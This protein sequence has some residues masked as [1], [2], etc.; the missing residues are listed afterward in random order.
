MDINWIPILTIAGVVYSIVLHELAHAVVACW[1]GDRTAK[2]LGRITLNPIPNLSVIGSLVVPIVAYFG[3]GLIIGW[4]KPVPVVPSNY[5]RRVLGDLLVSMAG[6][7]VN[8]VLAFLL[9]LVTGLLLQGKHIDDSGAAFQVMGR[10][11]QMNVLLA[12]FNLIPIPPLDGHH[13]A[14]Y[15]LPRRLRTHYERIGFAG[16]LLVVVLV[17][18]HSDRLRQVVKTVMEWLVEVVRYLLG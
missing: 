4:A 14:K 11:A 17:V 3:S 1:C 10:I 8:L 7:V 2:N 5:R 16:F 13:V 12:L 6:I 18:W 15:L 9:L